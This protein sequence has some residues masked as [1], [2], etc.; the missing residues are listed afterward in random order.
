MKNPLLKTGLLL[1]GVAALGFTARAQTTPAAT[2]ETWTKK[3]AEK[4]FKSRVWANGLK[5]NVQ[6][7]IDKVEFA[8]QYNANKAVWDKAFAYFRDTNLDQLTPGKYP[9]DGD[10]VTAAVTEN[11]TKDYDKTNWESHRKFIDMQYVV[12]GAEKIG[13]V[14]ID[15]ATVTKPYDETRDV[16]NYSAEGTLYEAKPGTIYVFF[17]SDVHR[18]NIKADGFDKDKKL[19]LKV[20]VASTGS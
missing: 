7:S 16:A 10:N 12:Q 2:T 8:K 14:P 1:L 9:V 18:P 4:W 17:P 19:V 5:L 11:P 6:E 20:R 13:V 15:K 3:K